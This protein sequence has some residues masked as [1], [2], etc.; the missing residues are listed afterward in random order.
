M[1]LISFPLKFFL[2]TIENKL[3]I[4][5]KYTPDIFH[6]SQIKELQFVFIVILFLSD[7]FFY[8]LAYSFFQYNSFPLVIKINCLHLEK[9]YRTNSISSASY[10]VLMVLVSMIYS[11][12]ILLYSINNVY[13]SGMFKN[14]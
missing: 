8:Y 10:N 1:L 2:L 5:D 13:H 12:L 9:H 7:L 11:I 4:F 6:S 3:R 14:L